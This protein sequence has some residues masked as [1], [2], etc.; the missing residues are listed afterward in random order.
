MKLKTA[1]LF[2]AALLLGLQVRVC[3]AAAKQP[4]LGIA[5]QQ[6]LLDAAD[7]FFHEANDLAAEN[8]GQAEELYRKALLRYER[9][10]ESGITNGM[11]YY[12]IGNIHYLLGQ[13]G[14]A[15]LNYRRAEQ[16]RPDDDNLQQNIAF[17]SSK[18][19]DA[20][21]TEPQDRVLH[22]VFFWHYDTSTRSRAVLFAVF[23][24]LFWV[25]ITLRLFFNFLPRWPARTF[26]VLFVILSASLAFDLT[27]G[28]IPRGV[29]ISEEVTARKG[30][31]YNYR[32]SF[33]AP[34]HAGTEFK[35]LDRRGNWLQIELADGRH[36]W[37]PAKDAGIV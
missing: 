7:S 10:A 30:D 19:V 37:I 16:Y 33:E 34:L 15:I 6:T 9:L 1:L 2:F 24:G 3:P 8:P 23:Y 22:T 35:L 11:I 25:A 26:L 28:A 31:G 27:S 13:L 20:I 32:S 18:K 36:C 5:E 4:S 14:K 12:N 21:E 17:V 29:I